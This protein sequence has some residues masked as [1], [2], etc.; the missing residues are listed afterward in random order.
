MNAKTIINKVRMTPAINDNQGSKF[1]DYQLIDALNAT[2]SMVYNTLAASSSTVL[3]RTADIQIKNKHGEL[4]D[5]FLRIVAVY[6][7]TGRALNPVPREKPIKDGYRITGSTIFAP[8]DITIEYKPFFDEEVTMDTLDD[9]LDLP[10]YFSNLLVKYSAVMAL[11]ATTQDADIIQQI[12]ADIY[13]IVAGREYSSLS[14]S[15]S[16][17][18]KL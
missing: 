12:T 17:P 15:E 14:L 13:S 7:N 9:D 2:L 18:W 16:L 10:A 8:T 1:S 11:G 3:N 5:D 6:D 4:P